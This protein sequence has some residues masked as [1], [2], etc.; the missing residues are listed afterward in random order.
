MN[1]PQSPRVAKNDSVSKS[2][3]KTINFKRPEGSGVK[4]P[5]DANAKAESEHPAPPKKRFKSIDLRDNRHIELLTKIL[6][7]TEE[8]T[9]RREQQSKLLLER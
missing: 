6:D 9:R 3:K 5:A 1:E 8:M 4:R 7:Q 2:V